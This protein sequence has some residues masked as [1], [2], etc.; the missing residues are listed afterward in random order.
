MELRE[1]M[2]EV[3]E[4]LME[5][6]GGLHATPP[7]ADTFCDDLVMFISKLVESHGQEQQLSRLRVE[8]EER[9]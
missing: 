1:A 2:D 7:Q 9:Y 3:I 8:E 4:Y 6:R 5:T